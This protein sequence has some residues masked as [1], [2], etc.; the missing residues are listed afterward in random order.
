MGDPDLFGEEAQGKFCMLEVTVE[1][2]GDEPGTL[3]SE[4]QYVHDDQGRRHSASSQATMALEGNSD[5]WISEINPGNRVD[6]V[7]VFDLPTS[8]GPVRA[9][10]HD[11]AFSGG[12][13]V[14]LISVLGR[15]RIRLTTRSV[16]RRVRASGRPPRGHGAR[17][18]RAMTAGLLQPV[19]WL[20]VAVAPPRFAESIQPQRWNSY[21]ARGWPGRRS[22]RRSSRTG[23]RESDC[24]GDRVV[25]KV[26][27]DLDERQQPL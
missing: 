26:A 23:R 21:A 17:P 13:E 10:L 2:T 15:W 25:L 9:E 22:A 16:R 3:F 4:N 6:G 5:S 18:G 1:N 14:S 19:L 24:L 27:L 7:F 20:A 8:A 12:V 11:S